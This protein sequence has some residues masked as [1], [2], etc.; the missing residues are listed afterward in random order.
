MSVQVICADALHA[1]RN[2]PEN[3]ADALLTDPPSGTGFMERDWDKNKGGRDAWIAWLADILREAYRVL[4]PGAHGLVWA[5]P[6]TSG[7]THRALEDAGFE[8]RDVFTHLFAAGMPKSLNVSK[9]IDKA[10]GAQRKKKRVVF[11]GELMRHGGANTRPWMESALAKGYHELAGDEPATPEA[12]AWDGWGTGL[13]PASEHWILVRKPISEPNV[14]ANVLRWGVGAVNIGAARIGS[15]DGAARD[16]EASANRRYGDR[17]ATDLRFAPGVRG[18]H[19]DGRWPANVVLSHSVDCAEEACTAEC[20]VALLDAQSGT[21]R[22]GGP[23]YVRESGDGYQGTVYNAHRRE[24]G[25][26]LTTHSDSGGASRFYFIAKPS[27]A[28]RH[29]AL[30]RVSLFDKAPESRPEKN[31]HPTVKPIDLLRHYARLI[32]PRNGVILD[33]FAGSGTTGLAAIAEGFNAILIEREEPYAA[34]ARARIER[35]T[36]EAG[37]A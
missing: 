29:D 36:A 5:L 35:A 7:W 10:L 8:V 31:S 24:S 1:L 25:S 28:E 23:G 26:K 21:L 4:K 34:I 3:S 13:K 12:A 33:C 2:L 6:R 14:A 17:G 19:E 20:P 9:A 18:G 32:T 30:K 11:K 22:S 15:G 16:A 27:P 37:A